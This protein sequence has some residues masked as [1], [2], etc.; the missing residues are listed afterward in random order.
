M[1]PS[2]LS[3]EDL[4]DFSKRLPKPVHQIPVHPT[5]LD[6]SG[7]D[8]DTLLVATRT[9]IKEDIVIRGQL[10]G[11]EP[12]T[13]RLLIGDVGISNKVKPDEYYLRFDTVAVDFSPEEGLEVSIGFNHKG[14]V[15]PGTTL[16]R[17][18]GG[19]PLELNLDSAGTYSGFPKEW[20]HCFAYRSAEEFQVVQFWY[21]RDI[22]P[23]VQDLFFRNVAIAA[24]GLA[25]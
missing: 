5:V 1:V 17:F 24:H 25:N 8:R 20:L 18:G 23:G 22:E 19:S 9:S 12:H 16:I 2:L 14:Y 6:Y 13:A 4:F 3:Y 7:W 10:L 15:V 11:R 21:A